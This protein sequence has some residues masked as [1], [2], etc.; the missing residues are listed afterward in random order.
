MLRL[1]LLLRYPVPEDGPQ[2]LKDEFPIAIVRKQKNGGAYNKERL[3]DI[4]DF[5][6]SNADT[7]DD[8][9]DQNIDTAM[10][11]EPKGT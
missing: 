11:A 10:L 2:N 9:S 4:V 6:D 8:D 1:N 5:F 7:H 3:T